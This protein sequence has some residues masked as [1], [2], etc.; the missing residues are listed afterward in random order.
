[1]DLNGVFMFATHGN[2]S[3][4]D[5][6]R[7]LSKHCFEYVTHVTTQMETRLMKY[8]EIKAVCVHFFFPVGN[9]SH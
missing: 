9:Q 3:T 1:M 5:K 4:I 7:R 2:I 6:W 8:F